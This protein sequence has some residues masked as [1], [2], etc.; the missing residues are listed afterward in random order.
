MTTDVIYCLLISFSILQN[1][2]AT[3]TRSGKLAEHISAQLR[4]ELYAPI[5]LSGKLFLKEKF[6]TAEQSF[7]FFEAQKNLRIAKL[8]LA[9]IK[10][11]TV[12]FAVKPSVARCAMEG[13]L[14]SRFV[15]FCFAKKIYG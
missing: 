1:K 14:R 7:Y 6:F 12:F 9:K 8:T 3:F 2:K 13:I 15:P 5:S 11:C 4:L 10:Q